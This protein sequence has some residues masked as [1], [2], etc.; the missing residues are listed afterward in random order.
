MKNVFILFHSNKYHFS[1]RQRT[2]QQK[3]EK[4]VPKNIALQEPCI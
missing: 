1:L 4:G 2:L 3:Q